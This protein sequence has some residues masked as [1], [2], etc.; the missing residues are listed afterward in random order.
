MD[1]EEDEEAAGVEEVVEADGAAPALRARR[2]ARAS[3]MLL[4]G[5]R[6]ERLVGTRKKGRLESEVDS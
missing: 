4:G 2:R 1:E 3:D 5:E 6:V